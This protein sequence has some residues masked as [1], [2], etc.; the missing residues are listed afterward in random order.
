MADLLW[1]TLATGT[2]RHE[3]GSC[4][5][6]HAGVTAVYLIE[7]PTVAQ[8]HFVGQVSYP[9]NELGVEHT[10]D[11]VVERDGVPVNGA[12]GTATIIH[13]PWEET[14]EPMVD[15][16]IAPVTLTFT[17]PGRYVWAALLDGRR[18]SSSCVLTVEPV[19]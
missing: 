16:L 10:L 6:H 1:A 9:D 4:T 8:L 15:W 11:V 12:S 3:D 7:S 14:T 13:P 18:A 17:E 5:I 2:E 19:A